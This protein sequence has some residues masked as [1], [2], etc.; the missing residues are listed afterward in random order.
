VSFNP[1]LKKCTEKLEEMGIKKAALKLFIILTTNGL[2][3]MVFNATYNNI[4]AISWK[5]VLLWN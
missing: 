3:V 1:Y 4:S 5:S 2:G